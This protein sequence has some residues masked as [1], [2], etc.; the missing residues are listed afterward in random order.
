M[1]CLSDDSCELFM[2]WLFVVS[3]LELLVL[4]VINLA[5]ICVDYVMDLVLIGKFFITV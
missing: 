2:F 5:S 3:V 1:I 4:L